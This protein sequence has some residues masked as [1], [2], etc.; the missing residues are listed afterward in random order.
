MRKCTRL[1]TDQAAGAEGKSNTQTQGKY[2]GVVWREEGSGI[3]WLA[4]EKTRLIWGKSNFLRSTDFYA[5]YILM[6]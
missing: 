1:D 3:G 6:M 5:P 4:E 2:G